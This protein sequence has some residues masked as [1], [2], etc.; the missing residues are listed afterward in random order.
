M[1]NHTNNTLGQGQPLPSRNKGP[2]NRGSPNYRQGGFRAQDNRPGPN[3]LGP[4]YEDCDSNCSYGRNYDEA[5]IQQPVRG[6]E[7]PGAQDRG[8][9]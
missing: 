9:T 8:Q 5:P 4:Y 1:V 2:G 3:K 6:R 7:D